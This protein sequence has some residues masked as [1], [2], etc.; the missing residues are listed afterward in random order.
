[1][2]ILD[3]MNTEEVTNET[4]ENRWFHI[5]YSEDGEVKGGLFGLCDNDNVIDFEGYPMNTG[6]SVKSQFNSFMSAH[7]ESQRV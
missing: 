2:S 6:S 1:M 3:I 7:I 5:Q 4:D